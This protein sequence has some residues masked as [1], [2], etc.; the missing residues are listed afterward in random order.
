MQLI[1]DLRGIDWFEG[2][3]PLALRIVAGITWLNAVLAC[4]SMLSGPFG[5]HFRIHLGVIGFWSAAGLL[6]YRPGW[7]LFELVMGSIGVGAIL[8]AMSF[9][10]FGEAPAQYDLGPWK[11]SIPSWVPLLML[12]QGLFECGFTIWALTH[13][14]LRDR[15]VE[16]VP[17]PAPAPG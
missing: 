10:L 4:V 9:V 14:R 16:P 1:D 3:P 15:F 7:R 11:Q 8:L 13:P 2:E 5:G 6:R 12:P 17:S